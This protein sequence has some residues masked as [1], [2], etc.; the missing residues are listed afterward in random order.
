MLF[1]WKHNPNYFSCTWT[2]SVCFLDQRW[3]DWNF[4]RHLLAMRGVTQTLLTHTSQVRWNKSQVNCLHAHKYSEFWPLFWR[5]GTFVAT[6]FQLSLHNTVF[7]A[8]MHEWWASVN[9]ESG[10]ER[11]QGWRAERK[12]S[13]VPHFFFK[14]TVTDDFLVFQMCCLRVQRMKLD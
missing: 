9:R 3:V 6:L 14:K 4:C 12:L 5:R 8:A 1:S 7:F 10:P 13:N 2:H 11:V